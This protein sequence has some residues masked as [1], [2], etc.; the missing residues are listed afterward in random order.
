MDCNAKVWMGRTYVYLCDRLT[1]GL[2]AAYGVSDL[3][4]GAYVSGDVLC[5]TVNVCQTISNFADAD[6]PRDQSITLS[7]S[8]C[9]HC[10][11]AQPHRYC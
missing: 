1:M 2:S 8:A 4:F 11:S 6:S 10:A 3:R 7:T 5:G 9:S